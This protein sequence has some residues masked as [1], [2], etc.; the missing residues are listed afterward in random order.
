M[1]GRLRFK[2]L[3]PALP[4][5][6]PQI[7]SGASN[8][9]RIGWLRKISRDLIHKPR[10]SASVIC[11]IFPGRHPRTDKQ[12]INGQFSKIY[13]QN[14]SILTGSKLSENLLCP[15][16]NSKVIPWSFASISILVNSWCSGKLL[17]WE[18]RP[19][20]SA[21]PNLRP[22]SPKMFP[23]QHLL[24]VWPILSAKSCI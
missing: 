22:H 9:K 6:L 14:N 2:R 5:Y 23:G 1:G 3:F 24:S 19:L 15:M 10:T 20:C 21:M 11:T 13:P 18:C 17:R 16:T 4:I 7:F 12:R 8:S